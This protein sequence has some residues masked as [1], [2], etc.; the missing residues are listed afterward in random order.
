M[1]Y[2]NDF[3]KFALSRGISSSKMDY[4]EKRCGY[5]NPY[6]LEE[7]QLNVSSIDIFSRL[8][9]DRQIFLGTDITADVANIV[10][11]Q[12]LWLDQQ[13]GSDI[14]IICNSGGG[15]VYDG[16]AIIDTMN[17]VNA[18]VATNVVG[19]AASM[20]AVISSSGHPGKRYILPHS[21]FMIHQPS[22]GSGGGYE[23]AS[24]MEIKVKEINRLKSELYT[25]LTE[26]SQLTYE[27]IEKM[28]DR[29][30]WLT[31]QEA[32]KY[33]FMDEI[34]TNKKSPTNG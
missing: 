22:H 34:I 20:A 23:Q 31:A 27:E 18:D 26:N 19:L 11:A 7:R 14:T 29:D 25:I 21:R 2:N 24:D 13:M 16:L 9:M 28:S 3:A 10:V 4:H 6:V 17:Y 33:G 8:M 30:H 12:L 32:I 15:S 1:S 5:M